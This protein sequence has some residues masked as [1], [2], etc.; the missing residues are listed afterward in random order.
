MSNTIREALKELKEM[1]K[2]DE[3]IVLLEEKI[4]SEDDIKKLKERFLHQPINIRTFSPYSSRPEVTAYEVDDIYRRPEDDKIAISLRPRNGGYYNKNTFYAVI[5]DKEKYSAK[6]GQ[7]TSLRNY[8][9]ERKKKHPEQK[10][11]YI[12]KDW[13]DDQAEPPIE[14]VNI[15]NEIDW[16]KQHVTSIKARF[17]RKYM[18]AFQ[19][20][21]PGQPYK[22]D[23][24]SWAFGFRM[25][26][27][28]VDDIPE[29]LL[30]IKNRDGNGIDLEHKTMNNTSYIWSLVKNYPEFF[31]FSEI[32]D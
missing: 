23:D 31:H 17:P 15:G 25:T 16:L 21:F 2:L 32:K 24:D 5:M 3:S 12:V 18:R 13:L 6:A 26:F 22:L 10:F 28:E 8:I 11:F 9:D 7:F 30:R 4:I 14:E 1:D 20:A 29:S 27:D 19:N